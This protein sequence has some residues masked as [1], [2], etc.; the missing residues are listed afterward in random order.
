MCEYCEAK[1]RLPIGE[2][3]ITVGTKPIIDGNDEDDPIV[4]VDGGGLC[5]EHEGVIESETINF[6]PMCG[7]ELGG[8][9]S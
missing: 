9:A 7:R 5:L 4:Y 3:S 6:C 1:T 8:D 2:L